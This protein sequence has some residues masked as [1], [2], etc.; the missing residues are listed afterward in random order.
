MSTGSV[1]FY[2]SGDT[3]TQ[4]NFSPGAKHLL[5]C[6]THTHSAQKCIVACLIKILNLN[7]VIA[8]VIHLW[9]G[10]QQVL[11]FVWSHSL[12]TF[13]GTA[14]NKAPL[15]FWSINTVESSKIYTV[16]S[17]S[18]FFFSFRLHTQ[19]NGSLLINVKQVLTQKSNSFSFQTFTMLLWKC[20]F[21]YNPT[22]WHRPRIN[23]RNEGVCDTSQNSFVF[24][25]AA[26]QR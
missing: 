6:F 15:A 18:R 1:M 10:N 14:M 13:L 8:G 25:G 2:V 24:T 16:A 7:C 26:K 5:V 4:V 19:A 20:A 22:F 9:N 17:R 11:L 23:I 21:P 12:T 3:S